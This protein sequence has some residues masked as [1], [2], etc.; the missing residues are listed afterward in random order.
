MLEH[1]PNSEQN[2]LSF[3]LMANQFS[4]DPL[5]PDPGLLEQTP[6]MLPTHLLEQPFLMDQKV[7][8]FG[9]GPTTVGQAKFNRLSLGQTDNLFPLFGRQ[10]RR[11]TATSQR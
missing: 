8:K 11:R 7:P 2:S 1:S 6:Q 3:R 5:E 10:T 9:Q 4:P